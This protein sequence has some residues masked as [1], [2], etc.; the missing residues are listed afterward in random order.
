MHLSILENI[1]IKT[2]EFAFEKYIFKTMEFFPLETPYQIPW[3]FHS[4]K[5]FSY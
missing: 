2:K 5:L 4:W 3:S 1:F